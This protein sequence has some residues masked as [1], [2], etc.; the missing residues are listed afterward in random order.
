[1]E[2]LDGVFSTSMTLNGHNNNF[3]DRFGV[4]P[5]LHHK[6]ING[7]FDGILGKLDGAKHPERFSEKK[8]DQ[9][10]MSPKTTKI[11]GYKSRF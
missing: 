1:M 5:W 2:T 10:G 6:I 3:Y 9:A 4:I 11:E 8:Y 7:W